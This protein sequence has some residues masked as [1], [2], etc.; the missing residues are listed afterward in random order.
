M[1]TPLELVESKATTNRDNRNCG[2]CTAC[3][4]LPRISPTEDAFFPQGKRGYTKCSHLKVGGGGCSIYEDRP[5]LCR[6]YMCLWRFG[7]INGDERRRP[8][9]LGIM[10][11]LDDMGGRMVVEASELWDGAASTESVQYMIS[12]INKTVEV[13][14]RFYGVPASMS[15]RENPGYMDKG[16]LLSQLSKTHPQLVADWC[17]EQVRRGNMAVTDDSSVLEDVELLSNGVPVQRH[18]SPK[19]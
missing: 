12:I 14:I 4:V 2:D 6:D 17:H 9:N 18:Y 7:V 3:C 10:F 19:R 11:T 8:D 5:S 15:I 13:A 16:R 1:K